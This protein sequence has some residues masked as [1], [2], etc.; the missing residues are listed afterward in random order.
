MNLS[1][2]ATNGKPAMNAPL[3][4][5]VTRPLVKPVNKPASLESRTEIPE[6]DRSL[7]DESRLEKKVLRFILTSGDELQGVV[8][9]HG[10][11]CVSV[12]NGKE[13]VLLYKHSIQR[14][15]VLEV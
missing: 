8:A 2:N 4:P 7:Y 14:V 12:T 3:R 11:Y 10:K 13:Q 6:P 5:P 15:A 9:R 1:A